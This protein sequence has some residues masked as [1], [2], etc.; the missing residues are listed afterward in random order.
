MALGCALAGATLALPRTRRALFVKVRGESGAQKHYERALDKAKSAKA[1]REE[2]A[3][4]A[5]DAAQEAEELAKSARWRAGE[6]AHRLA[7]L[8]NQARRDE[9]HL[10]WLASSLRSLRSREALQLQGDAASTASG[11]ARL[12]RSLSNRRRR[13][14]RSASL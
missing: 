14:A 9:V 4:Q 3:K 2:E 7:R 5:L 13:L 10:E 8:D 12:R 6:A 1:E 11:I